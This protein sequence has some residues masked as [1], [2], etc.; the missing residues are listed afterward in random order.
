MCSPFF[1]KY[2]IGTPYLQI[3]IIKRLG[4]GGKIKHDQ[5]TRSLNYLLLKL[6]AAPLY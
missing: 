6:Y 2:W 4:L 1:L 5:D 3:I